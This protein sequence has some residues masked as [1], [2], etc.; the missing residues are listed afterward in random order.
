MVEQAGFG[1]PSSTGLWWVKCGKSM[2][3]GRIRARGRGW[4]EFANSEIQFRVVQRKVL[5][6]KDLRICLPLF[7]E[8]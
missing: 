4:T 8:T 6:I 7:A 2:G 1:R 5:Y 3:Y